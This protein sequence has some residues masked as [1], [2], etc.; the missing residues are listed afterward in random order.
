MIS[1]SGNLV[2]RFKVG[3]LSKRLF[4]IIL[5]WTVLTYFYGDAGIYLFDAYHIRRAVIYRVQNRQ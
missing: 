2:G 5:N 4:G 1:E 3:F